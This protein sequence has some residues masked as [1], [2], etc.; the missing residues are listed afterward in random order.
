MHCIVAQDN[1]FVL[2]Q[3][4]PA[5]FNT[6]YER[7]GQRYLDVFDSVTILGRLFPIEDPTARPV[8]GP[9]VTFAPMPAYVGPIQYLAKRRAIQARVRSLYSKHTAVIIHPSTT[10]MALIKEMKRCG[11]PYAMEVGA[12]PYDVLA[13]G[14]IRHPLR[15]IL[16]QILPR[17]LQHNCRNACAVL[18]V[19]QS[20]L[21]QRYPCPQYEIGVSDVELPAQYLVRQPRQFQPDQTQFTLVL[22]GSLEQL[23]KG[24]HILLEAIANCIK[25]G[26][27]L[28]TNIIG[29]GKH[30]PELEQQARKLG[31]HTKVHFLGKLP[32]GEPILQQLDQ[33]DLFVMP[34]FQ[35]GL[36][37]AM[38]EAMARGLPCIGSSVGGIPELLSTEDLVPPGSVKALADKIYAVVTS[39][40]RMNC[41]S[42]RNLET[43][44]QYSAEKLRQKRIQ[45]YEFVKQ[46]NLEWQHR[47]NI[48]N[49]IH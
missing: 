20:A 43:A 15:P 42:V 48:V 12:D 19:T 49:P 34:S 36:P 18:Y 10:G 21:Q 39:P 35:E 23:Y 11:H 25:Q 4:R 7:F 8:E 1:R 38:V 9:G 46:T 16:R 27:N 29:E 28:T 13:P 37:R 45:F 32:A 47:N 3:G 40:Q 5:S 33:A 41:M 17:N 22:V 26:L 30:R 24:P 31:I 14:S 44:H 6:F 2:H